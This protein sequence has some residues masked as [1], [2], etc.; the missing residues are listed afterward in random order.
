M[1]A[2]GDASAMIGISVQPCRWMAALARSSEDA[3]PC[4]TASVVVDRGAAAAMIRLFFW[5]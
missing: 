1:F 4:A 5:D 2:I 3:M